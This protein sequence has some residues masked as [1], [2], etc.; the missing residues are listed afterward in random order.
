MCL[1]LVEVSFGLPFILVTLAPLL[2]PQ[3]TSCPPDSAIREACPS[4]AAL[5]AHCLLPSLLA[6]VT[7]GNLELQQ[8]TR[9]SFQWRYLF[10]PGSVEGSPAGRGQ[11]TGH[12]T[13]PGRGD[14]T[15]AVQSVGFGGREGVPRGTP[16]NGG[17]AWALRTLGLEG[18][19]GDEASS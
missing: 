12:S 9:C 6:S 8:D 10:H 1:F 5:G 17:R 16:G 7:K 19:G 2:L 11:G 3:G 15:W 14:P 13:G 4:P 18:E